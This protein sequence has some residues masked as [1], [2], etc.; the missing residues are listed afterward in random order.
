MKIAEKVA[1]EIAKRVD[2]IL[3]RGERAAHAEL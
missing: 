2:E 3:A 1:E